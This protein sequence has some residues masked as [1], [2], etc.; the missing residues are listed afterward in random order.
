[1]KR[2]WAVRGAKFLLWAVAAGAVFGLVVMVLWN[3]LIPSLTGWTEIT[4]WQA[5]ALVILSRVL[6]GGFRGHGWGHMHWRHRMH[7]RW[8]RMT[9]E[10]REKFKTGFRGHHGCMPAGEKPEAAKP[11]AA[12]TEA[13]SG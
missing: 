13:Q 5:L 4:F 3:W 11:E 6:F 1:M 8:G 12:E 2:Y 10:D 9:P 7:E